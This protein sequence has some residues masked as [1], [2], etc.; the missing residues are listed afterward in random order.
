MT[1]VLIAIAIVI[2]V[3]VII[4]LLA[5]LEGKNM[6]IMKLEAALIKLN[7][8]KVPDVISFDRKWDH[9]LK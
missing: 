8:G 7:D 6:Y 4:L 5:H 9:W 2:L 3:A 1:T